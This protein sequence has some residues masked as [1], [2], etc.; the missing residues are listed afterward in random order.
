MND[1]TKRRAVL[2]ALGTAGVGGVGYYLG[3]RA[4]QSEGGES[5]RRWLRASN[6]IGT[7]DVFAFVGGVSTTREE[8]MDVHV[9]LRN[10][11]DEGRT[12]ELF[13]SS[14]PVSIDIPP[15]RGFWRTE[16]DVADREPGPYTVRG[17]G[18]TFPI[19]L[20]EGVPEDWA[21]N[22]SLTIFS[23]GAWRSE[24]V[25]HIRGYRRLEGGIRLDVAFRART[26]TEANPT[27]SLALT[28]G[29]GTAVV[30]AD[31]PEGTHNT[32]LL[33]PPERSVNDAS[34]LVV[35]SGGQPIGRTELFVFGED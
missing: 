2:A 15:L 14:N 34:A 28:N 35:R 27:D 21:P 17:E 23:K 9:A 11:A 1:G 26:G 4:R 32:S 6:S 13:A 18:T 5:Y 3:Q 16:V 12:V 19:E 25:A 30:T 20:V 22:A 8:P 7:S 33:V 24:Y 10:R 29:E 31:V